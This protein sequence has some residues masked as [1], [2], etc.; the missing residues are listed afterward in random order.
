MGG[1]EGSQAPG[2]APA[3]S[4]PPFSPL[5]GPPPGRGRPRV[6]ELV[7][8]GAGPGSV[9]LPVSAGITASNAQLPAALDPRP[10]A[11]SPFPHSGVLGRDGAFSPPSLKVSSLFFIVTAVYRGYRH[12]DFPL[13]VATLPFKIILLEL[14]KE[15]IFKSKPTKVQW[16]KDKPKILSQTTEIWEKLC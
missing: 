13:T 11:P 16:H 1:S 3:P 5:W 6:S 4:P 15:S 10:A 7:R 12:N 2:G 9:P 8:A 14:K